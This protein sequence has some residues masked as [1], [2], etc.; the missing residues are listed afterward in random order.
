MSAPQSPF[1]VPMVITPKPELRAEVEANAVRLNKALHD[2]LYDENND[3]TVFDILKVLIKS[4]TFVF[5]TA[6]HPDI[7][8]HLRD[9]FDRTLK[10]PLLPQRTEEKKREI[11]NKVGDAIFDVLDMY[12][13]ADEDQQVAGNRLYV[14]MNTLGAVIYGVVEQIWGTRTAEHVR[15]A[16]QAVSQWSVR[17]AMQQMPSSD[18]IN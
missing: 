1:K 4:T 7:A 18:K 10:W 6:G 5:I 3:S 14:A 17:E 15:E 8:D 2:I 13:L 12:E 9:T 11:V 16:L